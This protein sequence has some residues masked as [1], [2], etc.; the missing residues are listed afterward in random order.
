MRPSFQRASFAVTSVVLGVLFLTACGNSSAASTSTTPANTPIP[1]N[2]I[3]IDA[4]TKLFTPFVT[5]VE[6]NTTVTITNS[7]TVAHNLTSVPVADPTAA[8][9]VN[10]DAAIN[11]TVQGGAKTTL[12]FTKVGLY[13]LYDATQATID[14]TYHRVAP[15]KGTAGFPFAAEAVIWVKGTSAGLPTTTKNSVLVG[16]DAF[17]LDFV[18]VHTGGTGVWHNYD[19]DLHYVSLAPSFAG[20]NPAKVGD[21]INKVLGTDDAPPTG[22][23]TTLTFATP[24]LYYYFCSS[25]ADFDTTLNRAKAHT[26][27]SIYPIPMEGFVL[28]G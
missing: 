7:D 8:S 6:A 22:G 14:P 9:F 2:G 26:D 19:T 28:V 15:H 11:Q 24:G 5:V 27:A 20:L 3:T 4:T 1:T 18:A 17:E 16:K 12:T 25:H 21:N 23:N 13:D 10:P